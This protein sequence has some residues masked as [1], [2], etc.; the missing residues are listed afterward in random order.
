LSL[1]TI[2]QN[3]AGRLGIP[4]PSAV[5][6]STNAQVKQLLSLAN[7][8][9]VELAARADWQVLTKEK[10]FTTVAQEI[11]TSSV[12][13]DYGHYSIDTMF[14]RSAIRKVVG[15]LTPAEWQAEK[16]FPVY[17]AVNPAFRF[18][19]NNLLFTPNPTAGQTVA[20]EYIG[21][22]WVL[23]IDGTTY[24]AAFT[25]D[26][27]TSVLNE[28]VMTDG[29]V[30]RFKSAKGLDFTEEFQEYEEKVAR[31]TAQDGGG[32]PR[33]SLHNGLGRTAFYPANIPE[34][35]WPS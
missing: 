15:P 19:G 32:K 13:T 6:S 27:D 33:L 29:V 17:T 28:P 18:R 25:A 3:A 4:S 24:K 10:T 26:D 35:T 34:G 21:L 1:L 12:A 2:I 5:V 30:W 14:N 7:K 20:Y 31:L 8:E 9:G 16:A 22:D 11:Q 23:A